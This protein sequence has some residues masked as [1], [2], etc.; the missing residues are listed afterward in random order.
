LG[1]CSH[2][3]QGSGGGISQEDAYDSP[4]AFTQPHVQIEQRLQ[5]EE[6]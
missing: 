2:L 5:T 1:E 3:A 6:L 4:G